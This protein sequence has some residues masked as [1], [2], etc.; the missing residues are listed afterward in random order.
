MLGLVD[1]IGKTEILDMWIMVDKGLGRNET[2]LSAIQKKKELVR[3]RYLFL[4]S[5][6]VN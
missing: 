2:W 5:I 1:E 3:D 6:N 4:N